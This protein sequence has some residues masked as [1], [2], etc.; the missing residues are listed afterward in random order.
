MVKILEIASYSD[1]TLQLHRVSA[2]QDPLG[3]LIAPNIMTDRA[4]IDLVRN[5]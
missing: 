1:L 2:V 4:H 5:R 3:S